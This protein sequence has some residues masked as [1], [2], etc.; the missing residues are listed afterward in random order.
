MLLW[1]WQFVKEVLFVIPVIA[2]IY[3]MSS[4]W[5]NSTV[6]FSI[7]VIAAVAMFFSAVLKK[8][9]GEQGV[10]IQIT[11]AVSFF[12]AIVLAM[13]M[14]GSANQDSFSLTTEEKFPVRL[15]YVLGAG[16]SF[17][18]YYLGAKI[19]HPEQ[20]I[21]IFR[22]AQVCLMGSASAFIFTF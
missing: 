7:S 17:V 9:M 1:N 13:I 22:L 14:V 11:P 18:F 12:V 15:F 3:F 20:K 16:F 6:V 4:H 2:V 8:T 19:S 10:G 21:V 5:D